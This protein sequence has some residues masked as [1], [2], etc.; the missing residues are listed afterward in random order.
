MASVPNQ[1]IYYMLEVIQVCNERCGISH[2]AVL[3]GDVEKRRDLDDHI[4]WV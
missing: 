4:E 3:P 1:I 2:E